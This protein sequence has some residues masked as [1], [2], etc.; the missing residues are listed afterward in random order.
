M[1]L[2][3]QTKP[4]RPF[5]GKKG[6]EAVL[7][8]LP[9]KRQAEKFRRPQRQRETGRFGKSPLVLAIDFGMREGLKELL[10]VYLIPSAARHRLHA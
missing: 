9:M 1:A 10:V 8:F 6:A 4:T 5:T 7:V 3:L 2:R